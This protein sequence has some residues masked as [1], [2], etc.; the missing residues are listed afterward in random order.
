MI[1]QQQVKNFLEAGMIA[2]VLDMPLWGNG[3]GSLM[4]IAPFVFSSVHLNRQ[5][6]QQLTRDYTTI[7]HGHIRLIIADDLY[8]ECLRNMLHGE[9][10]AEASAEAWRIIAD[11][12]YP[13]NEQAPRAWRETLIHTPET[14]RVINEFA[15]R[16]AEK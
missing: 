4:R 12:D 14:N 2:N 15:E 6:R 7:T 16:F 11:G 10:L 8:V 3:N 13:V 9:P 1:T 5:K